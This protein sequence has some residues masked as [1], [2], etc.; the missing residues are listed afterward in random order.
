MNIFSNC[1]CFIGKELADI[2][3]RQDDESSAESEEELLDGR[4]E[5]EEEGF[6]DFLK[7]VTAHKRSKT[8]EGS[9]SQKL[10]T[11]DE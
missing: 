9:K 2:F 7:R 6:T 3:L 1:F 10:E 11:V 5:N 8:K 4:E